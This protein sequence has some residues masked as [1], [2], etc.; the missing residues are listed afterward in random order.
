M[1]VRSSFLIAVLTSSLAFAADE[2]PKPVADAVASKYAGAKVLGHSQEK[3]GKRREIPGQH[4][5]ERYIL[6]IIFH[7]L[8]VTSV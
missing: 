4:D 2:L 6:T 7:E 1:N 3:E 8:K 5:L